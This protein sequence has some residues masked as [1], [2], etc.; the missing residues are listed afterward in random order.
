MF[1]G[2][3]NG[4]HANQPIQASMDEV[5]EAGGVKAFVKKALREQNASHYASVCRMELDVDEIL[6]QN[7][8]RQPGLA[9]RRGAA[10][11]GDSEEIK[12]TD[13]VIGRGKRWI[14]GNSSNLGYRVDKR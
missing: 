8:A 3:R 2:Q 13:A 11:M 4:P 10:G 1:G 6:T 14:K 9:A 12:V 7:A 5:K